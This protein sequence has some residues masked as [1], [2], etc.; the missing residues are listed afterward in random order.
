MALHLRDQIIAGLVSAL[1]GLTTTGARVYADRDTDGEPLGDD[2][3]PGLV[4]LSADQ[5]DEPLTLSIPRTI[6]ASFDVDVVA[7]VK[8]ASNSA[9]RLLANL[10]AKE[11]AA[12]LGAQPLL[13]SLGALIT[14][15]QSP[16]EWEGGA[17]LPTGRLTL[18]YRVRYHYKENAADVAG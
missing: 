1:T 3:L 15:S 13:A 8:A 9:A 17:E 6:A 16:P 18:R 5:A 2:M 11:V 4:I 10:V 12:A 14:P 7:H